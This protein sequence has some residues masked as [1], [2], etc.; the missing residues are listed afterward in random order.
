MGVVRWLC[1]GCGGRHLA[2]CER[3]CFNGLAGFVITWCLG[4]FY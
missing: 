4:Q 2:S 1:G 3:V